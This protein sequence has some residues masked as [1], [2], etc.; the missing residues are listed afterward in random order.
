MEA[1]PNETK[2]WRMNSSGV[3]RISRGINPRFYLPVC[4]GCLDK[5]LEADASPVTHSPAD[6]ERLSGGADAGYCGVAGNL[7][8]LKIILKKF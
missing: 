3:V 5:L 2:R 1:V 8:I 4:S 6:S 7:I